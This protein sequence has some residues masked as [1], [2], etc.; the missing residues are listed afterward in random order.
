MGES[1]PSSLLRWRHKHVSASNTSVPTSPGVYVIGHHESFHGLELKRIYVYVGETNNLR[2]R[3]DEHLPD[4]EQN[5]RLRVYLKR[6]FSTAV[7]W[8][9]PLDALRVKTVQD[10]LIRKIQPKFNTIGL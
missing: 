6:N 3:L 10:E 9:T 5:P 7:C 8:F 4:T 1:R 2:R